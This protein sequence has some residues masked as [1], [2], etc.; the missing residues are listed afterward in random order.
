MSIDAVGTS[1][2]EITEGQFESE[3]AKSRYYDDG[4]N[5]WQSMG[6]LEWFVRTI[7][8][9]FCLVESVH[10]TCMSRSWKSIARL[11]TTP[12]DI[13]RRIDDLFFDSLMPTNP[14]YTYSDSIGHIFC[15]A[16][17]DRQRQ[18]DIQQQPRTRSFT[19]FQNQQLIYRVSSSAYGQLD[20]YTADDRM[21]F[22]N[23]F[24]SLW[25]E[26][27]KRIGAIKLRVDYKSLHS[28][29]EILDGKDR[30]VMQ[31][32]ETKNRE[33]LVF[34]E[35]ITH[36]LVAVAAF[37]RKDGWIHWNVTPL[38]QNFDENKLLHVVFGT[39]KQSQHCHFPNPMDA[40]YVK[41]I[42]PK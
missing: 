40:P 28:A 32:E 16:H 37:Q 24:D 18:I 13:A 10:R 33:L 26:H 38:A 35:A 12:S 9:P 39:L 21:R 29:I 4:Q 7:L 17:S 22:R 3:A 2:E 23:S 6:W 15:K 41:G 36:E 14:R 19:V 11:E 1:S 34:R 5:S 20:F 42:P 30:L 8:S 25:D 27:A 31:V